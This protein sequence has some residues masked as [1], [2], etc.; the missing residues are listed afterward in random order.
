VSLVLP[1]RF[2]DESSYGFIQRTLVKNHLSWN[3][4]R[5]EISLTSGVFP[6]AAHLNSLSRWFGD[7]I[8]KCDLINVIGGR[9]DRTRYQIY[10]HEFLDRSQIGISVPKICPECLLIHGYK[11]KFWDVDFVSVCPEHGTRLVKECVNCSAPISWYSPEPS[12]CRCGFIFKNGSHICTEEEISWAWW[13]KE[14]FESEAKFDGAEPLSNL[15]NHRLGISIRLIRILGMNTKLAGR[16]RRSVMSHLPIDICASIITEGVN[17]FRSIANQNFRNG[18]DVLTHWQELAAERL[19]KS[20]ISFDEVVFFETILS[21]AGS[22]VTG[23][24]RSGSKQLSLR[25]D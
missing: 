18:S 12:I 16:S 13:L 20:T 7:S 8:K 1:S 15:G 14:M 6:T 24:H 19:L 3:W 17:K 10:G 25:F 11:R 5:N 22:D 4:L 23:L 9:G 2:E 21:C